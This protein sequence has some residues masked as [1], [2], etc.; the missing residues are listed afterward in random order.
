MNYLVSAGINIISPKMLDFVPNDSF[1][2]IPELFSRSIASG[3]ELRCHKIDNYWL[4]IGRVNDYHK[5]N[6][7]YYDFFS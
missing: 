7:E 5:A 1:L 6:E 2:D 4:D 3:L